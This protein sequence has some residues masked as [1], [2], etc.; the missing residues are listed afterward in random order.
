MCLQQISVPECNHFLLIWYCCQIRIS[1]FIALIFPMIIAVRPSSNSS[2]FSQI[3]LELA[4]YYELIKEEKKVILLLFKLSYHGKQMKQ[5]L[6][7]GFIFTSLRTTNW[8]E[9]QCANRSRYGE[10][11]FFICTIAL[12]RVSYDL[13]IV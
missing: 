6:K 1:M 4:I 8:V 7:R 12:S 11:S 9:L 10:L 3:C 2:V 13:A 5:S